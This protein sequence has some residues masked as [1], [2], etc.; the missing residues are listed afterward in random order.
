MP[1]TKRKPKNIPAWRAF[2]TLGAEIQRKLAPSATVAEHERIVGRSGV[3]RTIDITVRGKLSVYAELVAIDCKRHRRPVGVGYIATCADQA[4]DVG[5]T[6]TVVVS[7]SGFTKGA[8]QVAR[9][10]RVTLQTLREATAADWEN[11]IRPDAA[12]VFTRVVPHEPRAVAVTPTGERFPIAFTGHTFDR[13]GHDPDAIE[14]VFWNSWKAL[15]RAQRFIGPVETKIETAPGQAFV[16]RGDALV[17]VSAIEMS[18]TL[19]AHKWFVP[20]RPGGGH[21]LLNEDGQPAH[22]EFNTASVEWQRLMATEPGTEMTRDEYRQ[23]LDQ[24]S[25][26]DLD[27]ANV[28]RF[29]RLSIE[30][31][32]KTK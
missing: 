23:Y 29:I 5:A 11:V 4:A 31:I 17:E 16:R 27:L 6:I 30:T 21:V 26:G 18:A 7:N 12:V 2:E 19:R 20:L 15:P 22:Q 14:D 25:H 10:K 1:I 24:D 8:R 3:L 13:Q 9:D 32:P 28:N